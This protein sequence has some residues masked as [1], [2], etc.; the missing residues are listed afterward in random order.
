MVIQ[1]FEYSAVTS[2]LGLS[3]TLAFLAAFLRPAAI[4]MRSWLRLSTAAVDAAIVDE[5]V[6]SGSS[7]A[8]RR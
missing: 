4:K 3:F 7:K 2:T 5:N 8:L 6:S 1:D